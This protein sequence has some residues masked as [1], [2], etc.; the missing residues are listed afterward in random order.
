MTRANP[1][2]AEIRNWAIYVPDHSI[3][4]HVS[5]PDAA[6]FDRW[7]AAHDREVAATALR[8]AARDYFDAHIYPVPP[9][10]VRAWF[11]ERADGIE[12][13]S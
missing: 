9:R 6:A 7:L 10:E 3:G 5:E 11:H 1:T 12:A 13:T 8:D 2:T 4:M